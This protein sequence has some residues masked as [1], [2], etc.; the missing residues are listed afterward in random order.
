MGTLTKN[1]LQLV[2]VRPVLPS[3]IQ[4]WQA[5]IDQYH[6]LGF[7]PAVGERLYYVA[8]LGREWLALIG[9]MAGSLKVG[10]RD[11]WIGWDETIK[12]HRLPMVLNNYRFLILP[13]ISI[14]NLASKVLSLNLKRL[15]RDWLHYYG[16]KVVLAETFVDPSR[17]SGI[18]YRASGWIHLGS[19]S[20]FKRS[21]SKY[22]HHGRPKSVFAYKLTV[23]A[24]EQLASPWMSDDG[25]ER[26]GYMCDYRKLPVY[27][28]TDNLLSLM[29]TIP[30]RR[31][32]QGRRYRQYSILT[33]ATCAMLSG[34]RTYGAIG[35]WIRNLTP[36]HRRR[37][38]CTGKTPP[39]QTTLEETFRGLDAEQF[40]E[41]VNAWLARHC[42]TSGVK[43]LAV[44]GKTLKRSFT[45]KRQPM[46]L[47]SALSHEEK[48]IIAQR[49]VDGKTN[50]ITQFRPLLE[51]IPLSGT[52]VTADAMHCQEDHAIFLVREKNADFIFYT[53]GNQ[54]TLERFV[55]E[56]L[57]V[58]PVT[59]FERTDKGHG[60]IDTR[61][62]EVYE[63]LAYELNAVS[64]PFIRQ[65]FKITRRSIR[66]DK[67][68]YEERYGI[69]SLS[70]TRA[71]PEE[72]LALSIGHWGVESNHWLRDET[73]GEDKSRIRTGSGPRTMATLRNLT[74]SL[75]RISGE[76]NIAQ[77]L[78]TFGWSDRS[79][80][81]N[82][83]GV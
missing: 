23:K 61:G 8:T 49:E 80:V 62:I 19:T 28:G 52:V 54:P 47:L 44:D 76:E 81:L 82:F 70:A 59:T 21:A 58:Q 63:P 69:T 18:C 64:F 37:F 50:E 83:V 36:R 17:Y 14:R 29:R 42:S 39:S 66:N 75:L 55:Q 45:H 51:K 71:T 67:I 24:L 33:M 32:R 38:H 26:I 10:C 78:R 16:H 1:I 11:K 48:V 13:G 41:K 20:G 35:E 72:I 5:L 34:A 12:Y 40:D 56:Q 4:R 7:K 3:E 6:Y 60:R 74:I 77:T 30:D 22:I 27:S 53:K 79:K 9:W 73:F 25:G 15:C 46:H 57:C 65:I 68:S 2:D 31:R 43:A